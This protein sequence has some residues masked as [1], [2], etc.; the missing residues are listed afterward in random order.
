MEQQI[1]EQQIAQ[2]NYL[3]G[4]IGPLRADRPTKVIID[5]DPG[6]D[7]AQAIVLALYLAKKY[8]IEVMGL[9]V[10]AGNGT[11][12]D[13][14]LNA[15]M[16][17]DACEEPSIPIFEGEKDFLH[18][19]EYFH[20][21]YG[22]DGF[23]GYQIEKQDEIKLNNLS[24]QSAVEFLT[25]SAAKYPGEITLIC[26]APLTN[27]A[28]AIQKDAS[29]GKNIKNIVI[30]GGTIF[31]MGN[32]MYNCTEFNFLKDPDAANIVFTNCDHITLVPIEVSR[33]FRTY[34]QEIVRQAFTQMGSKTG[35]L[36]NKCF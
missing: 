4:K 23:G 26:L 22:P 18:P 20:P 36:I 5:T 10:M 35:E 31:A 28:V 34:D 3:G 25:E 2:M 12:R 13:V 19:H 30:L 33:Q 11:L 6:G 16:I 29:F 21:H 7:D 1:V 14:T 27:I 8:N 32:T 17:L 24:K 15:Q 9:T